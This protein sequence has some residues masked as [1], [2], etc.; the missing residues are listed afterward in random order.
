MATL[1]RIS[2]QN[3]YFTGKPLASA[4]ANGQGCGSG[5]ISSLEAHPLTRVQSLTGIGLDQRAWFARLLN[6]RKQGIASEAAGRWAVAGFYFDECVAKLK[7]RG[8]GHAQWQWLAD[9]CA[10]SCLRSVLAGE[11]YRGFIDELFLDMHCGFYNGYGA[12]ADGARAAARQRAH[13]DYLRGLLDLSQAPDETSRALLVPALEEECDHRRKAGEFRAAVAVAEE[14]V[15]R[16]PREI[17][18][19]DLLARVVFERAMKSLSSSQ[20]EASAKKDA[21]SLAAPVS[22]LEELVRQCPDSLGAFQYASDL[23]RLR[24]IRMANSGD[25]SDSMLEIQKS[26]AYW[27]GDKDAQEDAKK[28]AEL[29]RGTQQR[30]AELDQALA[31]NSRLRLS[32]TGMKTRKEAAAAFHPA[33]EFLNSKERQQVNASWERAQLHGLWLKAGLPIPVDRW[34]EKAARFLDAISQAR[35]RLS[36]EASAFPA[37]WREIFAIDPELAQLDQEK[38]RRYLLN[39]PAANATVESGPGAPRIEVNPNG[40]MGIEPFWAWLWTAQNPMLKIQAAGACLLLLLSVSLGGYR[41]LRLHQREVAWKYLQNASAAG[42][43]LNEIIDCERFFSTSPPA[44]DPRVDQVKNLYR[45]ALARWFSA[46][47]GAPDSQAM[48]HIHKY[49]EVSAKWSER[50]TL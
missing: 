25:V 42:D 30:A 38:I 32:A 39:E 1:V 36:A 2:G 24:A 46:L 21:A 20:T 17:K 15:R 18:Y 26:L 10:R 9:E 6:H 45:D 33:N 23:H 48:Q 5:L 41:A 14:L 16:F 4:E 43:S 13:V 47:P 11:I 34:D 35:G 22:R 3:H 7:S 37:V 8:P 50:G 40:R 12:L 29:I 27:P 31:R 49:A 28:I 19:A 44:T